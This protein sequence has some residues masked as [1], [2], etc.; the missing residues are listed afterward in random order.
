MQGVPVTFLHVQHYKNGIQSQRK[1][2]M[3][4]LILHW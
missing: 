3:V 4:D 2:H 1:T